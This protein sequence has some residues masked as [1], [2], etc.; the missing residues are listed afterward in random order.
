MP[1]DIVLYS[2]K[3]DL[4]QGMFGQVLIWLLEVL[5][6]LEK[7]QIINDK[8]RLSFHINAEA[9]DNI[10]PNFVHP[11]ETYYHDDLENVKLIDMT[12]HFTSFKKHSMEFDEKSFAVVNK[13]WNKYFVVSDDIMSKIPTFDGS[14]TLGI[15]YR[16]TDKNVQYNETNSITSEEFIDIVLDYLS[17]HDVHHLYCCSDEASFI[18]DLKN[19]LPQ[20]VTVTEYIRAPTNE[21]IALHRL[22][23]GAF[24]DKNLKD[25]LAISALV[26][27]LALSRCQTVLKTNSALSAFSKII[28]PDLQLYTVSAMKEKWFPTGLV[29]PYKTN[30]EKVNAILARTMQG[31]VYN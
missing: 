14:K 20:G 8:S 3:N 1:R 5:Y 25:N 19:R 10:I 15:H 31:H 13:I 29:K 12:Q 6:D 11:R 18:R 2:N 9:Y 7:Q 30:S 4:K 16:G 27:M 22:T 17:T 26:D 24:I 21:N 23:A 28:N